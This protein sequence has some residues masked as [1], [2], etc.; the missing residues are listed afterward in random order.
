M[1]QFRLA[2]ATL[3]HTDSYCAGVRCGKMASTREQCQGV[4]RTVMANVVKTCKTH[5][6]IERIVGKK[7]LLKPV[8]SNHIWYHLQ[9]DLVDFQAVPAYFE[10][11]IA[12]FVLVVIDVNSRLLRLVRISVLLSQHNS[13][14]IS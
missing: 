1:L 3:I 7:K 10:L 14:T 12:Y 6:S 9:M 13:I 8:V 2:R 4:S 11:H 5:T